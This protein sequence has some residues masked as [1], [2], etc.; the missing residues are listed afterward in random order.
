MTPSSFLGPGKL[1][2]DWQKRGCSGLEGGG[3]S[4]HQGQI[5]AFRFD[6]MASNTGM[7]QGACIGLSKNS[8]E[9]C[10]GWPA[11]IM[12]R[13]DPQGCL[14]RLFLWSLTLESSNDSDCATT[15]TNIPCCQCPVAQGQKEGSTPTFTCKYLVPFAPEWHSFFCPVKENTPYLGLFYPPHQAIRDYEKYLAKVRQQQY[16]YQEEGIRV[17]DQTYQL[18]YV[19][20][21]QVM[22]GKDMGGTVVEGPLVLPQP[23]MEGVCVDTFPVH[24]LENLD[25]KCFTIMSP[26]KCESEAALSL[27]SYL[28]PSGGV[29]SGSPSGFLQVIGNLSSLDLVNAS[30]EYK[31]MEDITNFIKVQGGGIPTAWAQ[32]TTTNLEGSRL[33]YLDMEAGWCNNV[34]LA[35][36]YQLAWEGPGIVDIAATFTL[37]NIPVFPEQRE[38]PCTMEKN[39]TCST[40][41][42][43]KLPP[44]SATPLVFLLQHFMVDFHHRDTSSNA[45]CD[46]SDHIPEVDD[47]VLL[48][49]SE[50]SG[51]PGYLVGRPVLAGYVM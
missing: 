14:R 31:W 27:A 41:P 13:G 6:T 10:F 5:I 16:S 42:E 4:G 39:Q 37:G 32:N 15:A 17:P 2:F 30:V 40:P 3:R 49:L 26:E 24:F 20:G 33:P 23:V 9:A 34:V 19:Y 35:V 18:H 50:R 28:Q 45:S 46:P 29:S 25:H 7:V 8:D 44:F 51:K 22:M 12:S 11:A 47:V 48:G 38:D 21:E 43:H 1:G 36:E